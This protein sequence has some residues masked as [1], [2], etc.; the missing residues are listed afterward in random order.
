[1]KISLETTIQIYKALLIIILS[2]CHIYGII[3]CVIY[4]IRKDGVL[5]MIY[6]GQY[7]VLDLEFFKK[8][9]N[10]EIVEIAA[11]RVYSSEFGEKIE[12]GDSFRQLIKPVQTPPNSI[13]ALTKIEKR[14]LIEA[15]EFKEVFIQFENWVRKNNLD[16][17]F[18]TFGNRDKV[19]LET[20]CKSVGIGS[21]NKLDFID[22]QEYEILQNSLKT[23]PSLKSVVERN[24]GEF[25]GAE[26]MAINDAQNTARVLQMKLN[27][28]QNGVK[29]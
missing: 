16:T 25:V 6:Q 10:T 22:I 26:H 7:I 24:C 23:L 1:M 8:G 12:E 21:I 28:K 4:T 14:N 27:P 13:F 15:Q 17:F 2:N 11:T 3:K 9:D 5:L 19:V 29:L 20:A 18:I